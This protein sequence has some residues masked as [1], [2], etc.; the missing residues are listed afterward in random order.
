[1]AVKPVSIRTP[2]FKNLPK[3]QPFRGL[4]DFD[5]G[6]SRGTQA[7]A[8]GSPAAGVTP[9]MTAADSDATL[10][11]AVVGLFAGA[12]GGAFGVGSFGFAAAAFSD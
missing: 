3:P 5:V 9:L 8:T 6:G 10:A 11:A 2:F 12:F 7:S 4:Q 1:M